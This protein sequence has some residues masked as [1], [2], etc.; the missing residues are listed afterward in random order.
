MHYLLLYFR[1]NPVKPPKRT[2][3]KTEKTN[4]TFFGRYIGVRW[5]QYISLHE[6]HEKQQQQQQQHKDEGKK[7]IY[8]YSSWI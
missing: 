2:S 7:Y 3:K 1:L 4:Q 6:A 5:S 8:V